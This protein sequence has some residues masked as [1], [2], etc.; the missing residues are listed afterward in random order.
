[1]SRTSVLILGVI[2]WTV[3]A[4]DIVLHLINGDLVVP[5]GM[6]LV[7]VLWVALRWQALIG[8]DD[9]RIAVTADA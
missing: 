5:V 2:C 8:R 4:A 7:F 9:Q 1:M 3:V 6:A